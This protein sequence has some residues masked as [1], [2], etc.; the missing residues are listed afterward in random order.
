MRRLFTP[1][2]IVWLEELAGR[3]LRFELEAGTLLVAV[4]ERWFDVERLDWLLGAATGIATRVA[5][6]PLEGS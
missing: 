2:F 6:V 3:D 1:A 4:P 5:A